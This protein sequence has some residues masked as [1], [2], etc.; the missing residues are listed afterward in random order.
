MAR[1]AAVLLESGQAPES[2][3]PAARIDMS[4]SLAPFVI[5]LDDG[6]KVVA[7]SAT[8]RG[9]TRGG[10]GRRADERARPRRGTRH[11]AITRARRAHRVSRRSLYRLAGRG[12]VVAGPRNRCRVGRARHAVSASD[13]AWLVRRRWSVSPCWARPSRNTGSGPLMYGN[14][15][16]SA[17][18]TVDSE[19]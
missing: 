15:K 17:T 9:A 1:D 10:P 4:R 8:L 11:V 12:F 3:L 18:S 19:A 14:V 13:S 5:V 2:V 7:S 16:L 6:G